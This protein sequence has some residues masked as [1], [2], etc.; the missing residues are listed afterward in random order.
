MCIFNYMHFKAPRGETLINQQRISMHN[1][2]R[3]PSA[4][5]RKVNIEKESSA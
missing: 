5:R 2:K 1:K 4:K 3:N